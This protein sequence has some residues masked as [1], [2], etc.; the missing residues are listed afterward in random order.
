MTETVTTT[1]PRTEPLERLPFTVI[2]E[3]IHNLDTPWEPWSIQLELRV[4]G[5]L[6]ES[7]LR[8]AVGEGLARHPMARARQVP[9]RLVDREYEWEITPGPDLDPLQVVHCPDDIALGAARAGLQ[10]ISVPLAESPP[11]RIRLAHHPRGD[12]VMVNV[13]HAAFDGF[14][15]L[16]V[17]HSIAR[18]YRG[19]DDPL[20]DVTLAQAR[21]VQ[22]ILRADSTS[23]R[24]RRLRLLAEKG[25]D[26][27]A[28]P[29]R[30]ASE[31]GRDE[32]GYGF[33]HVSVSPEKSQALAGLELPGT[34]N[35]V[36]VAALSLA[37]A[38]W[39]AEHDAPCRRIGLLV[40]VNLRP[41][42]W[43]QEVATN[44]VLE[45]RVSTEPD[46][47]VSWEAVLRA[48]SEQTEEIKKGG[49]AALIEVLGSGPS[50]PVWLKQQMDTFLRLTGNR[51][52]DTAVI[53]NLGQIK[54]PPS[55]GEDAGETVEL[56]F[57]APARMPCGLSMGV[58]SVASRLHL[59]FRY[60]HPLWGPAAAAAFAQL[61]VSELEGFIEEGS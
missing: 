38:R 41:K 20:P 39:N 1:A 49:G 59:V 54:E 5:R 31:G 53:S 23:T 40:P 6:D 25:R 28:A 13:N 8:Q 4:S 11:L 50:L 61:Y 33:H 43:Q 3:A 2:D 52:V 35:D 47:R 48:V 18:S 30:L 55:F 58:A 36:L 14:G 12:L 15:A 44:F 27:L 19:S 26:I 7:R 56:W 34:V 9:V 22:G 10:S 60:R 57:S 51:L 21:D 32:R 17:L 16:R 45:S 42:E 24:G 46:D 37:V 29:C